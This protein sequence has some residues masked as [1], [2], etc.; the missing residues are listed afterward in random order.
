MRDVMLDLETMG[1]TFNAPIV[2]I[3]AV[4]FDRYTG[5]LGEE[6]NHNIS[7]EQEMN[8][9]FTPDGSTILWWLAQSK[10]AQKSVLKRNEWYID[11]VYNELNNFLKKSKSIWSHA[12]FDY[13]I[14]MNHM[15]KL[16]IKPKFHY[17][18]AKDIRTLVD[19]AGIDYSKED[20]VGIH[21]NALDDCKFQINYCV[22]CFNLIKKET[23]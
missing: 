22:K 21:H 8:R 14:L 7:L 13:V 9:G 1:S 12:T 19:L 11:E 3:G 2:Q 18:N 10:E 6:F 23:N 4:Y 5:E 17:R 20:R 16:Q 15:N